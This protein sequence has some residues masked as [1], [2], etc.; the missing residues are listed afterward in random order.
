MGGGVKIADREPR[1]A[2]QTRTHKKESSQ[3]RDQ[4]GL[5]GSCTHQIPTSAGRRP[6]G[7]SPP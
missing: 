3:V 1:H 6:R 5:G 7:V 2:A 4:R